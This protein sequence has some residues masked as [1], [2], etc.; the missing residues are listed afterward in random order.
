MEANKDN[1]V[2]LEKLKVWLLAGVLAVLLI[3]TIAVGAML[4]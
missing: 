1:S 2:S 3:F 4:Y